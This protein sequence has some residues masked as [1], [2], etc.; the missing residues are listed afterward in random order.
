MIMH[1]LREF[2]YLFDLTMSSLIAPFIR[3]VSFPSY[4]IDSI[5]Y[6]YVK[7]RKVL[8][9]GSESYIGVG[10]YYKMV[11]LRGMASAIPL[12]VPLIVVMI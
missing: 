1:R 10:D 5:S 8:V 3:F 12:I 6:K 7:N 11:Y 4:I 2:D 9:I